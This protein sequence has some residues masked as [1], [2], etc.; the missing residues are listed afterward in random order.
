[1]FIG[2]QNIIVKFYLVSHQKKRVKRTIKE[3]QSPFLLSF[4]REN[5]NCA[6]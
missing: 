1:M 5:L 6:N 4:Q 2:V 3:I